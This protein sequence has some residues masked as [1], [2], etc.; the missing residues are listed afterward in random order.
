VRG[1]AAVAL[2]ALAAGA[3]PPDTPE[4]LLARW[5]D[6]DPDARRQ[7][8]LRLEAVERSRRYADARPVLVDL[9]DRL[10]PVAE[11]FENILEPALETPLAAEGDGDPGLLEVHIQALAALEAVREAYAPPRP[12]RA[13]TLNLFLGYGARALASQALPAHLR[14]RLFRDAMRNV[15]SLEGR[16]EPDAYTAFLIRYRLL[17]PLLAMARAAKQ[18]A[19]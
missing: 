17:P 7:I 16:V 14:L 18:P 10:M 13:G 19:L 4:T 12:V 2:L 6:A 1:T 11:V 8:L 5:A 15:R 9:G 3:E